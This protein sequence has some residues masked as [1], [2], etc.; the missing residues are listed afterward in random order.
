MAQAKQKHTEPIVD[1]QGWIE[2]IGA[3]EHN[4][5]NIDLRI[6]RE[7]LVVITGI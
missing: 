7:K 6:P 3:K 1:D 2:V 5:K 4:L